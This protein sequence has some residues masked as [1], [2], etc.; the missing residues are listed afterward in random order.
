MQRVS[1]AIQ[2]NYDEG[3]VA[4][5]TNILY[6]EPDTDPNQVGSFGSNRYKDMIPLR[7]KGKFCISEPDTDPN[8]VG[9]FGSDRYRD[10]IPLQE[11]G[12][13]CI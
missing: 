8:Q 7:E 6:L 13:F 1:E 3:K 12:K 5:D 2:M 9:S 11:N 10:T 4:T